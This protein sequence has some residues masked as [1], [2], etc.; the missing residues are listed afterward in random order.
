M[1]HKVVQ[2]LFLFRAETSVVGLVPVLVENAR[3]NAVGNVV[4]VRILA[5]MT[6]FVLSPV[7]AEDVLKLALELREG[8]CS[9]QRT[10]RVGMATMGRRTGRSPE[11]ERSEKSTFR[12]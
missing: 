6:R 7:S 9:G 11:T 4:L 3:G 12:T 5:L 8:V 1:L 2:D 10:A